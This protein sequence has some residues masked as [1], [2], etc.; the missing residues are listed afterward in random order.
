MAW[1]PPI[2][3]LRRNDLL[4]PLRF[5]KALSLQS[6]SI[7]PETCVMVYLGLVALI[8]EELRQNK[9]IRL[10]VLGD[11]ALAPQKARLGW[12]GRRQ[13]RMPPMDIL[14]FYPK[15]NYRRYF[16]KRRNDMN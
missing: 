10:P 9:F 16:G 15:D 11:M 1:K 8:T 5:Y 14:R 6:R 4:D 3:H 12:M 7:D 13:V 2:Q